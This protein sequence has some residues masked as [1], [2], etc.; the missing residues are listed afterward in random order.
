MTTIGTSAVLCSNTRMQQLTHSPSARTAAVSWCVRGDHTVTKSLRLPR[1]IKPDHHRS[2]HAT[3]IC[4]SGS[5]QLG[6]RHAYTLTRFA[7]EAF[8]SRLHA[9]PKRWRAAMPR[10]CPVNRQ[11]LCARTARQAAWRAM[12]GRALTQL[13]TVREHWDTSSGLP[14]KSQTALYLLLGSHRHAQALAGS[15]GPQQ[16]RSQH[17]PDQFAPLGTLE[18][19]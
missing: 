16:R 6:T 18:Q 12:R 9:F 13:C 4:G 11:M 14:V 10:A 3:N 7:P 1:H 8:A 15:G 5:K 19:C 17:R 2:L